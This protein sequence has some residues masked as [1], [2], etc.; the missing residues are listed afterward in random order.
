MKVVGIAALAADAVYRL[1]WTRMLVVVAAATAIATQI[2]AVTVA[3]VIV[4]EAVVVGE[5]SC[6]MNTA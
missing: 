6:M 1:V 5:I 2:V 3:A 4:F